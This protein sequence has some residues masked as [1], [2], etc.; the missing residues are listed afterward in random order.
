MLSVMLHCGCFMKRFFFKLFLIT[1][2]SASI[3][4][5]LFGSDPGRREIG[6]IIFKNES[7][8]EIM[9]LSSLENPSFVITKGSVLE[10]EGREAVKV[11]VTDICGSYIRCSL[12]VKQNGILR[13]VEEG[14]KVFYTGSS[15][16]SVK[17]SDA[18]IA[19]SALI[20][21][22]EDFIYSI[23]S[24]D[25]PAVIAGYVEKFAADI[26]KMLPEMERI[27]IRYPELKRFYSEPPREL[28]TEAETLKLLEPALKN[29][30]FK[31]HIYAEE[32]AVKRAVAKLER[33]MKKMQ[34]AG[35]K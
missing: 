27:N 6:K 35:N 16:E 29:I 15:N 1:I 3:P 13:H 32:P 9:V 26:E 23:E 21:L 28:K 30:F 18:K 8:G 10:T 31:I 12:A 11:S 33:V 24:V 7:T 4:A 17:Y 19:L 2:L 25:D 5:V 22:Y 20:K 34:G 14:E